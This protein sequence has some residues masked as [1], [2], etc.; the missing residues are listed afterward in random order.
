MIGIAFNF[1][2]TV[3][4]LMVANPTA[5]PNILSIGT[6]LIIPLPEELQ[7]EDSQAEA[8]PELLPLQTSPVTCYPVRSGGV[9]CFWLVTNNL[10]QYAENISGAIHLYNDQDEQAASQNT[11]TLVNVLKPGESIPLFAYFQPPVPQWTE[12]Q[13]QLI[14][15]VPAN[16]YETRYQAATIENLEVKSSNPSDSSQESQSMT[17]SGTLNYP[18]FEG[19]SAPEYAWVVAAAYDTDSNVVGVRRW[20][21]DEVPATGQINFTFEVYSLG[22][23]IDRVELLS[24]I[25]AVLP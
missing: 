9:W 4:E 12:V 11:I 18:A 20:Q 23:P 21:A 7:G 17:V 19:S 6:Q 3:D 8:L 22:K 16:Q 1:G 24:E 2:I 10:D 15:A 5:N 25:P 14:S 13:G